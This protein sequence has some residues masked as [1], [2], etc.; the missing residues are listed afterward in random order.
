MSQ[1][2]QEFHVIASTSELS[3]GEQMFVQVNEEEVLLCRHQGQYF[4]IAYHCSHAEFGLEGGSMKDNC[5]TCPYHGAE[6]SLLDGSV[7]SPPAWEGIKTYP[8]KVENET[9]S[10]GTTPNP[11]A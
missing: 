6:F 9:I 3:E 5:I 2:S 4:A 8:L 1:E 7:A 10:M 11:L